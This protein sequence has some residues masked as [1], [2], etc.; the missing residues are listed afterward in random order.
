MKTMSMETGDMT[1]TTEK[2]KAKPVQVVHQGVVLKQAE[3]PEEKRAEKGQAEQKRPRKHQHRL[4][5][6]GTLNRMDPEGVDVRRII[7]RKAVVRQN[8]KVPAVG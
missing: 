2:E 6:R 8:V 5:V 3:V 1:L 7:I 4:N